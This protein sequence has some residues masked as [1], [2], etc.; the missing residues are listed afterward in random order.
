MHSKGG[1]G[2]KNQVQWSARELLSK[3]GFAEGDFFDQYDEYRLP[4]LECPGD[5][6]S[7]LGQGSYL[8]GEEFPGFVLCLV[9][10]LRVRG[11]EYI[12]LREPE[13]SHNPDIIDSFVYAGRFYIV[14]SYNWRQWFSSLPL[15]LQQIFAETR[16]TVEIPERKG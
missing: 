8:P 12:V 1:V 9:E 6:S 16:V 7:Q 14:D 2:M 10:L 11:L 5:F 13:G 15:P 3:Y 4:A